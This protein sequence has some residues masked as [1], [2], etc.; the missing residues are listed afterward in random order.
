[1]TLEISGASASGLYTLTTRASP[2]NGGTVGLSVPQPSGGYADGTAVQLTAI[3][4]PGY[5][6]SSWS[7]G[8]AGRDNPAIV[9][10]SSPKSVIANF[11]LFNIG[12]LTNVELVDVSPQVVS[13]SVGTYPAQGLGGMAKGFAIEGAYVVTPQGSGSFTLRFTGISDPANVKV[14]K[15]GDA[16]WTLLPTTVAGNNAIDVTM[17][18]VDPIIVLASSQ[19]SGSQSLM[20]RISAF[21]GKISGSAGDLDTPVI[22]AIVIVGVLVAGAVFVFVLLAKRR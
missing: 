14:Y 8:L 12:A 22:V 10:M 19:P 17:N 5:A 21:F 3:A 1:M 11:V 18:V 20:G 9:I 4:S 15:V 7:G 2:S 13:I 6:F 16:F